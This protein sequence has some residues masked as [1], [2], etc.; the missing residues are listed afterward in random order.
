MNSSLGEWMQVG[1]CSRVHE[2]IVTHTAIMDEWRLDD[3]RLLVIALIHYEGRWRVDARVWIRSEDGSFKPGR[4]LSLGVWHLPRLAAAI[5]K[6]Y[7]GAIARFLVEP[8]RSTEADE[9]P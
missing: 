7:R 4:G 3:D 2:Q 8:A 1:K 5:E 9:V 6:S